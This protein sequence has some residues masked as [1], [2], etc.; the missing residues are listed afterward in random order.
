MKI[1]NT[2]KA[3]IGFGGNP[4]AQFHPGSNDVPNGLWEEAKAN[5]VIA[6][7]IDEG[8]LV[9]GEPKK[10]KGAAVAATKTE[11]DGTAKL[12]EII[13]QFGKMN[14]KDALVSIS[15]AKDLKILNAVF[16][17]EKRPNMVK[18]L[19]ARITE[20]ENDNDGE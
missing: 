2:T 7:H 3:T 6:H 1:T 11:D 18:A 9:E 15:A 8:N 17:E 5:K 10:K 14:E 19:E 20:L 16:A 4:K 12:A 13:K